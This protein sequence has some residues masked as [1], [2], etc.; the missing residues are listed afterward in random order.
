MGAVGREAVFAAPVPISAEHELG[1][2]DCGAEPSLNDWLQKRA[3]PNQ[4]SGASRTYVVCVGK[5]VVG[6]YCLASGAV[7]GTAATGRVKRNM[8]DP[9]PVVV[10]G[11][12]AV[13]R[14]WQG[15]QLGAALLRDAVLRTLRAAESI[16]VRAMLIH[17]ISDGAKRFYEKHGFV[18]SPLQPM[19]LM[20]TLPDLAAVFEVE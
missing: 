7:L 17:A 12:L 14:E 5:R 19:T 18:A 8:P 1:L 10:L 13:D 15:H 11:R 6:Y 20:A 3:L 2:F 9:I 16:G 4:S